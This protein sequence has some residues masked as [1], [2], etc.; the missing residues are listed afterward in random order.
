MIEVGFTLTSKELIVAGKKHT[1]NHSNIIIFIYLIGNTSS[2]DE[3][4]YT[5][6]GYN[7]TD[8]GIYTMIKGKQE[9]PRGL[10]NHVLTQRLLFSRISIILRMEPCWPGR[11][12][13]PMAAMIACVEQLVRESK[14]P[15]HVIADSAFAASQAIEDLS[16]LKNSVASISINN[17]ATS[18]MSKLYQVISQELPA[19]KV[20]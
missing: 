3:S 5:Y 8:V 15:H 19:G 12:L 16:V 18:G 1:T 4:I 13:S 11:K 6:Y 10:L 9:H 2:F 17:S 14:E 20:T 7:A